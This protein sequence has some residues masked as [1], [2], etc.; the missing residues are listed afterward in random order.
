MARTTELVVFLAGLLLSAAAEEAET[1]RVPPA[2]LGALALHCLRLACC[3]CCGGAAAGEKCK[4]DLLVK[5][6]FDSDTVS[7][8]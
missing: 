2:V 8:I 5:E 7:K 4:M 3:C 6:V 1:G